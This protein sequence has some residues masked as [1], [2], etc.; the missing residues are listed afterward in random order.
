MSTEN[1]ERYL[2][3]IKKLLNLA[4][5][6]TNANEAANAMNQ[7]QALMRQHGI[8]AT[9]VDLLEINEE[10][11]KSAP[12]HAQKMP[13]YMANL[14]EVICRAFGVQCYHQYYSIDRRQV[15][16]YGPNERPTIAAYAFDVLSRQMVKARR[17]YIAGLRKNIKTSTKT[18]RADKFCEGWVIGV[19][20]V[21]DDFAVTDTEQ[22]LIAAYHRKL[23]QDTG[24]ESS[25]SREAKAVRGHDDAQTAGYLAGKNASIHH[26]VT[27]AGQVPVAR[28]G[29]Q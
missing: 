11:S 29:R 24:L 27:G 6:S 13:K 26:A 21:I 20:Q 2:Q 23:V 17:E 25:E 7:A 1:K 3:K 12:S 15:V 4:R 28:I 14:A 9:D 22:T 8:T 18:G 10:G 19:Y 5:R 16:F